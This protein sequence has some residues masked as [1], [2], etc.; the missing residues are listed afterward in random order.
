[1]GRICNRRTIGIG[2]RNYISPSVIVVVGNN[3]TCTV[4]NANNISA[5]VADKVVVGCSAAVLV[6]NTGGVA[7]GI[8]EEP[9]LCR[10]EL[11]ILQG[12]SDIVVLMLNT[13]DGF[14]CS[15]SVNIVGVAC[16]Y[17][18]AAER[19]QLSAVLPSESVASVR[20]RIAYLII[21]NSLT[22][23][24]GQL[25]PPVGVV[26]AVIYRLCCRDT[27]KAAPC[28]RISCDRQNVSA[29]VIS[30]HFRAVFDKV[31]C[32]NQLIQFVISEL[33][34][35]GICRLCGLVAARDLSNISVGVIGVTI[36]IF[37]DMFPANLRGA[38]IVSTV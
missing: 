35:F 18:V 38:R 11:L 24:G 14:G 15:Q 29:V 25:V 2:D 3:R 26:I 12:V 30:I 13:V 20:Q 4:V 6:A 17:S 7:V 16:S 33:L 10:A 21:G 9:Q 28:Q 27:I 37:A 22:V 5:P 1:M 23:I 19:R 8:I 31:I 32:T 36:D 34:L